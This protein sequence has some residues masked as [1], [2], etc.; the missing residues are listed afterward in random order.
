MLMFL[1]VSA[2]NRKTI[3]VAIEL[4]GTC[5]MLCNLPAVNNEIYTCGIIS[6]LVKIIKT[7]LKLWYEVKQPRYR[8]G[9]GPEGGKVITLLF[10]ELDARRGW[11]VRSTPR[12][13]FTPRKT[14]CPLYWKLC[15][16]QRRS[17]RVK[18][19]ASTGIRSP[20]RPTCSSVAIPTELQGP[21]CDINVILKLGAIFHPKDCNKIIFFLFVMEPKSEVF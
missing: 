20:D 3:Q 1:H 21:N 15:G 11:V 8:S 10:Q 12:P 14:R 19:L 2:M 4:E 13:H 18:N 6:H 5:N 7:I 9:C 17:G 16:P